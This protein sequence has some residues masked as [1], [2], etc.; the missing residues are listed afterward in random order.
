MIQRFTAVTMAVV[1]TACG[2]SQEVAQVAEPTSSAEPVPVVLPAGDAA[3]GRQ[4]FLDLKCTACHAVPTET[5]FPAPFAEGMG[6]ALSAGMANQDLSTLT[7][8]LVTPSH[9][10]SENLDEEL[11]A[12]LKEPYRPWGTSARP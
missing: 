5:D 3:A 8:S 7:A 12:E 6:P 2:G 1:F 9:S 4:A 10:V 11:R